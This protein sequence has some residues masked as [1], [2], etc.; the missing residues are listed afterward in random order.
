M[1]SATGTAER[2]QVDYNCH[3]DVCS[4]ANALSRLYV[5]CLFVFKGVHVMVSCSKVIV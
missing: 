4:K 3:R 5:F 2:K 1:W